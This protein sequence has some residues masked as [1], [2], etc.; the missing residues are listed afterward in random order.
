MENQNPENYSKQPS[1]IHKLT[2]QFVPDGIE[3]NIVLKEQDRIFKY[4][5][6]LRTM[7]VIEMHKEKYRLTLQDK[8]EINISNLFNALKK[9][10]FKDQAL[11]DDLLEVKK[12][13]VYEKQRA[14]KEKLCSILQQSVMNEQL[15]S[16]AMHCEYESPLLTAHLLERFEKSVFEQQ[17]EKIKSARNLF[18]SEITENFRRVYQ[19]KK[20]DTESNIDY[21]YECMEYVHEDVL[22]EIQ[23][24]REMKIKET[25][26][27]LKETNEDEFNV[28]VTELKQKQINMIKT[29]IHSYLSINKIFN[30]NDKALKYEECTGDYFNNLFKGGM[31]NFI[32]DEKIP[33]QSIFN[34]CHTVIESKKMLIIV[35][36]TTIN[37]WFE[38]IQGYFPGT[39]VFKIE[40]CSEFL[41]GKF[42]QTLLQNNKTLCLISCDTL[43]KGSSSI[44][45]Y[46]W[47]YILFDIT[48]P[49]IINDKKHASIFDLQFKCE[50]RLL[51]TE[52]IS[53]VPMGILWNIL[54]FL[55]PGAFP[56]H[57]NYEDLMNEPFKS[58]KFQIEITNKEREDIAAEFISLIK[59][60]LPV[61]N[62]LLSQTHYRTKMFDQTNLQNSIQNEILKI[63][64]S[65]MNKKPL[66]RSKTHSSI[67]HVH[68]YDTLNNPSAVILELTKNT[69]HPLLVPYI[70]DY[71]PKN[72]ERENLLTQLSGKFNALCQFLSDQIL[73]KEVT[74]VRFINSYLVDILEELF[75]LKSFNFTIMDLDDTQIYNFMVGPPYFNPKDVKTSIILENLGQ[76]YDYGSEYKVL[77]IAKN[78]PDLFIYDIHRYYK[79]FYVGDIPSGVLFNEFNK[80]YKFLS[81]DTRS[82]QGEN[83]R[84]IDEIGTMNISELFK[85]DEEIKRVKKESIVVQ[86]EEELKESLISKLH[87]IKDRGRSRI[88]IFIELPPADIYP[89]YYEI[90]QCP[91]SLEMI[92]ERAE[93]R[94]YGLRC[95]IDDLNLMFNNAL[96]YNEEGSFVYK[97]ALYLKNYIAR[98]FKV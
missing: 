60:F 19:N 95:M 1:T 67:F 64:T 23:M 41:S 8:A 12:M 91:I 50:R 86:N 65:N 46:D 5:R 18:L 68:M 55:A 66:D 26:I 76:N 24:K 39:A 21:F 32:F 30:T 73:K 81:G 17:N 90:I 40:T 28:Y 22:N 61:S 38:Y 78:T 97:D 52:N 49:T 80:Y 10:D 7:Q 63:Y 47:F 33:L 4:L 56:K 43:E 84:S 29:N 77:F 54:K 69:N 35:P 70:N 79:K 37:V 25:L 44:V 57:V 74:S 62:E 6:E 59:T 9:S 94:D 72:F 11:L 27:K 15:V 16:A 87:D 51:I 96:I 92:E 89:D 48:H 75:K 83:N 31:N 36:K 2:P 3:Q 20:I 53:G 13:H 88:E 98:N 71:I 42:K 34:F 58:I 14:M 85:S 82:S 45:N 93:S